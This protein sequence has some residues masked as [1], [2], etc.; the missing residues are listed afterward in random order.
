[1]FCFDFDLLWIRQTTIIQRI[2]W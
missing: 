1:M 2:T